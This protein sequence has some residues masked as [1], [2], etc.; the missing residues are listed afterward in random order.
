MPARGSSIPPVRQI[1]FV[2][3]VYSK[4]P[5]RV[6]FV[7]RI[8]IAE[9]RRVKLKRI[10]QDSEKQ[11]LQFQNEMIQFLNHANERRVRASEKF[12]DD[13]SR[14][15]L[16][17]AQLNAKRAAQ[18]SRLRVRCRTSWWD[19]FIAFA[20]TERVGREE[21]KFIE[22]IARKPN[23]TFKDYYELIRELENRPEGNERCLELLKWINAKCHFA[24]EEIIEI[25][26]ADELRARRP[27]SPRLRT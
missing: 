4:P 3:P 25:L 17:R 19:E 11:E 12:F 15:G 10:I 8:N 27:L 13:M 7:S 22:R 5:E 21:E 18:R 1:Q 9:P 6:D 24:D 2:Q 14:Y 26:K 23:L 16:K 20:F